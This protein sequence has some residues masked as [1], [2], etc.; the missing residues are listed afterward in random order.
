VIFRS[1]V[2]IDR[3]GRDVSKTV[4]NAPPPLLDP[5][6]NTVAGELGGNTLEEQLVVLWQQNAKRRQLRLGL[7]I[8]IG[9]LGSDATLAS[10]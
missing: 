7:E 8:V 4:L 3:Q 5:I 2:E 9:T 10:A 6:S 1:V